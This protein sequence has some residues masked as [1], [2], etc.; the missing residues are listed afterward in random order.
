MSDGELDRLER[1]VEAAR[2]RLLGDVAKLRA[3]G[4]VSQIRQRVT[5]RAYAAKDEWTERAKDAAQERVDGVVD[6]VK[7]RVAANPGAALAIAA[8]LGWR[9]YRHPPGASVLVGAGLMSLL[10]TDPEHPAA[11][12]GAAARAADMA[13]SMR[14]KVRNWRE[15]DGEYRG[16]DRE[17]VGPL[18]ATTERVGDYVESARAWGAEARHTAADA[19]RRAGRRADR[20]TE[21]GRQAVSGTVGQLEPRDG[22]LLGAAALA[23]AGAV[24]LAAQRRSRETQLA[25]PA[26]LR[27]RPDTRLAAPVSPR[28]R[29]ETSLA[30]PA[31]LRSRSKRPP[32]RR[33]DRDG[34]PD[35]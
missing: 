17:G 20:W 5:S 13:G 31:V 7:A 12:A 34:A 11:G 26:V 8:G 29:S 6:Q 16:G 10:R 25:A 1:D 32:E 9:L 23:L 18:A 35:R 28:L 14:T 2:A 21:S 19:L 27:S 15:G 4:G 24:G 33:P 30:A 22:F 3:P